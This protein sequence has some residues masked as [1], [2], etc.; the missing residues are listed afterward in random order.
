M[1]FF[2]KQVASRGSLT[3]DEDDEAQHTYSLNLKQ[4]YRIVLDEDGTSLC[5]IHPANPMIMKFR[6]YKLSFLTPHDLEK[7]YQRA[8]HYGCIQQYLTTQSNSHGKQLQDTANR[9]ETPVR[10]PSQG[11]KKVHTIIGR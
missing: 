8:E 10:V 7:W 1:Y 11:M 2:Q 6:S 3:Y 9:T 5:T 4:D